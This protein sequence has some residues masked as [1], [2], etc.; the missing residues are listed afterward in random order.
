MID[1]MASGDAPTW[2]V[3]DRWLDHLLDLDAS[4]QVAKL[5]AIAIEN[6]ALA[7]EL[8]SL[9][10]HS[11]GD[12][13]LLDR[14][15]AAA[16]SRGGDERDIDTNRRKFEAPGDSRIGDKG[17]SQTDQSA[18]EERWPSSHRAGDE[19]GSYH[20]IR[21][22]GR[23]GMGTVW[24]AK[25]VDGELSRDIALKLPHSLPRDAGIRTRFKRERDILASLN[26]PNIATLYDAGVLNTDQPFLALEYVR[27]ERV[28]LWCDDRRL[29]IADRLQLFL[30][31]CEAVSY[32]HAQLVVHRDLKPANI[33]V[34]D[35]AQVKL[36]DFGIAKLMEGDDSAALTMETGSA[37][38]PEYAAPEQLDG[39]PIS[40]ATDIYSLGILLYRLLTGVRPYGMEVS[41]PAQFARAVLE[42]TPPPLSSAVAL[43]SSGDAMP[44]D[45]RNAQLGQT[46][47]LSS[48][49]NNRATTIEKLQRQLAGD[50]EAIVGKALK[51]LPRER[52]TNVQALA[53]DIKHYLAN[54][55]IT[56]RP[57]NFVYR[58]RKFLRRNWLPVGAVVTLLIVGVAGITGIMLQMQKTRIEADRATAIKDFLIGVFSVNDPRVASDKPRNEMTAKE[59]LDAAAAK[60][61]SE[62]AGFPETQLELLSQV[63]GIYAAN[64]D[65]TRVKAIQARR[66]AIALELFGADNAISIDA[67]IDDAY[68][69][70]LTNDFAIARKIL[71][72]ADA[73]INRSG[74]N[75][76]LQR[77]RWALMQSMVLANDATQT[78]ERL[79]LLNMA[80]D[81]YANLDSKNSEYLAV[82]GEIGTMHLNAL[83]YDDA[84]RSINRSIELNAALPLKR[85]DDGQL[86]T[87]MGN[88]ALAQI[89]A[90]LIDDGL[91]SYEKAIALWKKTYGVTAPIYW[92]QRAYFA[93]LLH[94]M[95]DRAR[96]QTM[97]DELHLVLPT[98]SST[99]P[100]MMLALQSHAST[101]V[102]EG[103]GTLAIPILQRVRAGL[104]KSG[105]AHHASL[106]LCDWELGEAYFSASRW[107][108]AMES[109]RSSIAGVESPEARRLLGRSLLATGDT[110]QAIVELTAAIKNA[111]SPLLAQAILA[112]ADL[113]KA[114][115]ANG[116]MDN[117]L[118]GSEE[119]L[120]S[121]NN[122]KGSYDVRM[123]PYL[124]RVRASVL[125]VTG[126]IDEA[127]RL[128]DEAWKASLSFDAPESVTV[129]RRKLK[130]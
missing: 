57:D 29:T 85:R 103:R 3:I 47:L 2:Q 90:G 76:S 97:F 63:E 121:W 81:R 51:K 7:E 21:E 58:L 127:Q 99:S 88:L 124:Q 50:L 49:A 27:G 78:S 13:A 107:K 117:A 36:L 34:L 100:Y 80:Q 65:L 42:H 39:R 53:N 41:T 9:L 5:G 59:S 17:S 108:E 66:L 46:D 96:A 24:L 112:R 38:T 31:I 130:L 44:A 68:T 62:F 45:H 48:I 74:K 104:A 102:A 40:V 35:N 16:L 111:K 14:P 93:Q 70:Y 22:L 75:E 67:V 32:A 56:A 4:A 105:A 61:E 6:P 110:A 98:E 1:P 19:V 15:S 106:M 82:L 12:D 37:L 20:L 64:G 69:A 122:R 109:A 115:Q 33:L 52:Y 8:R 10:A 79:R 26:H 28:D 113:A 94:A 126:R 60:I 25:R 43:Q 23:G 118:V 114:Q 72:E 71:D 11:G 84:I 116:D 125:A 18:H 77:G 89:G 128:E 54:E 91:A 92:Q 120:Q 86:A 87:F 119:A 101:L 129:R 83:R 73:A 30:Q 55:P 123:L 95:G